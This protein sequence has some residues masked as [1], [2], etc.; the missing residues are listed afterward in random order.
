MTSRGFTGVVSRLS[1]TSWSLQE[2][3]AQ[4]QEIESRCPA[5][6]VSVSLSFSISFI[7]L[8]ETVKLGYNSG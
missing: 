8:P 2:I 1:V 4:G 3:T 6:P 5:P 7:C